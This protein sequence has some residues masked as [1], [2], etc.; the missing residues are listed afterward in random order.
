M[1]GPRLMN[2]PPQH[3][4]LLPPLAAAFVFFRVRACPLPLCS[5]P[6]GLASS[7]G[8]NNPG[9]EPLAYLQQWGGAEAN[10]GSDEGRR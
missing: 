3:I 7:R 9:L 8:R 2:S 4:L 1:G 6:R 5:P 10:D